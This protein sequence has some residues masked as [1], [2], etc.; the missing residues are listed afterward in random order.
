MRYKENFAKMFVKEHSDSHITTVLGLR[1]DSKHSWG[2]IIGARYIK[3]KGFAR[4]HDAS[5][6]WSCHLS[7]RS[8]SE[9][10]N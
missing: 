3:I 5:P 4:D 8:I 10:G 1:V 6:A 9:I 2:E 7:L